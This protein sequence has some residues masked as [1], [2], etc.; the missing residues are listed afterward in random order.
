[1]HQFPTMGASVNPADLD[2][3]GDIDFVGT[4][5]NHQWAGPAGNDYAYWIENVSYVTLDRI[6]DASMERTL[7]VPLSGIASN[8]PGGSTLRITA[9]SSNSGLIPDPTVDYTSPDSTGN[10]TFTRIS[11]EAGV[12]LITVT[13]EDAG[14]DGDLS[15]ASDNVRFSRDFVVTADALP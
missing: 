1:M 5:A 14:A 2:Q 15:T 6:A 7:S 13:V 9:S 10:L 8:R 12:S 11:P 4:L 3:D